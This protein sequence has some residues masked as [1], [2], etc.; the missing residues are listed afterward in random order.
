MTRLIV[1][2]YISRCVA[3]GENQAIDALKIS[4]SRST[5]MAISAD[6]NR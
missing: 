5:G 6:H 3:P 4:R 2:H 1:Q